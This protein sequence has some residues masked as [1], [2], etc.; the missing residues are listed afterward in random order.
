MNDRVRQEIR[1]ACAVLRVPLDA[2]TDQIL[3][4][5]RKLALKVHPDHKRAPDAQ[6]QF[7]ELH[8]ARATLLKY[9]AQRSNLRSAFVEI[10]DTARSAWKQ[11]STE[12]ERKKQPP[13]PPPQSR[14]PSGRQQPPTESRAEAQAGRHKQHAGWPLSRPKR[15][16]RAHGCFAAWL[17]AAAVFGVAGYVAVYSDI[18][19]N[20][21]DSAR[22]FINENVEQWRED[23]ELRQ[24]E[25]INEVERKIHDGI[26]AQRI[27]SGRHPLQWDG[28]LAQI[29]RAHSNDMATRDYY[30]HDTLEGLGPTDRLHRAG[31]S[32][33]KE[34]H[35]GIAENIAITIE[36]SNM[37]L[38]ASDAVQ[39]WID[40]LGHLQNLL[41]TKHHATGVGAAYGKWEGYKALY[42]TQVFC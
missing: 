37:N 4:A 3:K 36:L 22:A 6:R 11:S 27:K 29:A 1:N 39:G 24:A 40:S 33:R 25:E 41:G 28:G 42:L 30:D 35:W 31:L 38:A 5:Y 34:T 19:D 10:D 8:K 23:H 18:D 20:L 14:R 9:I 26:N 7:R 15:R 12:P 13:K 32:C 16:R 17:L 2:D 21:F